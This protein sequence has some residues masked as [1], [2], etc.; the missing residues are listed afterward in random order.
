MSNSNS[1]TNNY[2]KRRRYE[3]VVVGKKSD[4]N[5]LGI[6][7]LFFLFEQG[8]DVMAIVATW[9][10]D[11]RAESVDGRTAM[12]WQKHDNITHGSVGTRSSRGLVT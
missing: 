2:D 3:R 5:A 7:E 10:F 4:P 1:V 6:L 12:L 9:L 8:R 11:C